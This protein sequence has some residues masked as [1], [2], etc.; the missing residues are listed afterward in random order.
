MS[1]SIRRQLVVSAAAVVVFVVAGV[2]S[3]DAAC[4]PGASQPP[5]T[6]GP[7]VGILRSTQGHPRD[8]G[9]IA[10]M[11]NATKAQ[12]DAA[13]PARRIRVLSDADVANPDT[14]ADV[15]VIVLPEAKGFT[16][17]QR[18]TLLGWVKRGG[19]LVSLYFDGR[20]DERGTP[21][22]RLP[23][24]WGGA[25]EWAELSPAFG[26][27]FVNDVY[28]TSARFAFDPTNPVVQAAARYCGG[29]VPDYNWRRGERPQALTGEL[30]RAASRGF[31]PV[32]RLADRRITYSKPERRAVPGSVFAFTNTFRKGRVVD[33]GFNFID[34][35]QPW[36][37]QSYY[38]GVDATAPDTSVAL[39]RGSIEWAGGRS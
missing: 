11:F 28:M 1:D 6:D 15:G 27:R 23:F 36:T 20:D 4:T 12:L 16:R 34:S 3:A 22:I 30:V 9:V 33:F 25:S 18:R 5:V 29:P 35:L 21:L 13:L 24:G 7:T 26:A 32:A 14:I 37:F 8:L 31:Q 2:G 10:N 19:G 38:R 39:L 17:V